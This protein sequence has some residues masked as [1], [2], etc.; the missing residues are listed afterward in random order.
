MS[1]DM[2]RE[3]KEIRDVTRNIAIAV[4]RLTEK[5]D[6]SLKQT[7]KIDALILDQG[8]IK[9]QLVDFAGEVDSSRRERAL[10]DKSFRTVNDRLDEHEVKIYRLES[11]QREARS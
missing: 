3:I 6:A 10:L 8:N 7:A 5:M 11:R 4:S 1:D 2:K 9:E